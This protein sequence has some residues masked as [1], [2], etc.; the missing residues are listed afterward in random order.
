[1]CPRD[2][3]IKKPETMAFKKFS[4]IYDQI[5]PLRIN[6][7]GLGEPFL[8]KH[9]FK[10]SSY[11]S[12]NGSVVNLP[13]NFTLASKY[14]DKIIDSGISQIKVS[15]DAANRDTYLKIRGVDRFDE[16][17]DS[18]KKLNY[19]KAKANILKPAIR[20]NFAVQN[21]NIDEVVDFINLSYSL[22]VDTIYFQYLEFVGL[23]DRK[24]KLVDKLN[25]QKL[26]QHLTKAAAAASKKRINT[27]LSVW[28]RDLNLYHNK[29]QSI[30]NFKPN[31]RKCY[32]PW[33]STFIEANGDVKPC[34]VVGWKLNEGKMGNIFRENFKD[35]WNN[36][37]YRKLRKEF[38]NRRRPF[39]PCDT[40]IPQNIFNLRLIFSKMLPKK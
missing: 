38:K 6:L 10:M 37:R 26:K 32:F 17:V 39:L 14:L 25:T 1:M 24:P 35:I 27:N 21:E 18:I 22:K 16:I 12:E 8:N 15:I 29:M 33:F 36:A 23:E 13:S 30:E 31:K 28:L 9:I 7:S 4:Y 34:P 2:K 5:E 20:F 3:I 40:C 11:A 19:L